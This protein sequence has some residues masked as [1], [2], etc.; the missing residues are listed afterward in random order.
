VVQWELPAQI[1]EVGASLNTPP[2][3]VPKERG[4]PPPNEIG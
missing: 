2:L 4:L 3:R 1:F